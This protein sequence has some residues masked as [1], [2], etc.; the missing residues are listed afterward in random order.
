ME[1]QEA[2]FKTF[3]RKAFVNINDLELRTLNSELD[4]NQ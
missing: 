2:E 4:N 3:I 1:W